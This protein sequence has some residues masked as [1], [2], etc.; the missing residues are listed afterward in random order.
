MANSV[1]NS[2]ASLNTASPIVAINNPKKAASITVIASA[3]TGGVRPK[4]YL[5]PQLQ[6]V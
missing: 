5:S 3:L 4:P 2:P 1:A 6:K